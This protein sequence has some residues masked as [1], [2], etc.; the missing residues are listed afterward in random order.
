M[1]E[2]KTLNCFNNL[3]EYCCKLLYIYVCLKVHKTWMQY[4]GQEISFL[5]L[6]HAASLYLRQ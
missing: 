4:G 5:N 2:S 6:V 3:Q 1:S